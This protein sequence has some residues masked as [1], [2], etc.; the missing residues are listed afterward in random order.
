MLSKKDVADGV[1][2][3]IFSKN[4]CTLSFDTF[5][6]LLYLKHHTKSSLSDQN[7]DVKSG[8]KIRAS[9]NFSLFQNQVEPILQQTLLTA[10]FAAVSGFFFFIGG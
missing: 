1:I 10:Y 2:Y 4:I 3:N 8:S 6:I 5:F 7:F 9:C